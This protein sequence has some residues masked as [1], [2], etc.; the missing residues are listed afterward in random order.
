MAL[1]RIVPLTMK[2]VVNVGKTVADYKKKREFKEAL[3]INAFHT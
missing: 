2:S 3:S 1:E